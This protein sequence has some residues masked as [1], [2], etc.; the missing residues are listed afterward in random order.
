MW[1]RSGCRASV[2]VCGPPPWCSCIRSPHGFSFGLAQA[3]GCNPKTRRQHSFRALSSARRVL[4][5]ERHGARQ[6]IQVK[7]DTSRSHTRTPPQT[8]ARNSPRISGTSTNPTATPS[9]SRSTATA[10]PVTNPRRTPSRRG[11]SEF[12][13]ATHNDAQ[14]ATDTQALERT[15]QPRQL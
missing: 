7:P 14:I 4:P 5:L 6:R 13:F 8:S 15:L 11:L 3:T 10:A 12:T 1:G 2:R 9:T